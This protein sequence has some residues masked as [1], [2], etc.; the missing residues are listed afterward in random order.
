LLDFDYQG[1]LHV[2]CYF[3]L[4]TQAQIFLKR[5]SWV[6]GKPTSNLWDGIK[7]LGLANLAW[8]NES[9]FFSFINIYGKQVYVIVVNH[10]LLFSRDHLFIAYGSQ[11]NSHAYFYKI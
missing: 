3:E 2:G 10:M 11:K 9:L 4:L 1:Q 8:Q 6:F 7:F 5:M